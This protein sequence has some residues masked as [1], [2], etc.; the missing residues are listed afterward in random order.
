MKKLV[1][2]LLSSLIFLLLGIP[3]YANVVLTD[4]EYD[5]LLQRLKSDK[6][7]LNIENIRWEELKKSKPK[8]TY[9]II[10]DTVVIQTIEIPI[11]NS[12]PLIY[13]VKFIVEK[14]ENLKWVPWTFQLCGTVETNYSIGNKFN[15][16][17]D[18]KLGVRFFST[19]PAGIKF[20]TIGFN[21]FIGIR[22]AGLSMSY[23]LPK[24][25]KNTS[26]HVYVGV[27]YTAKVAYGL[28]ISL[29]F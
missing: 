3:L 19:A 16:Y 13:E 17:P 5:A 15:V 10:D 22:S 7:L 14:K 28:G 26:I 9:E 18:V 25:L 23:S 1:R 29:N 27:A 6:Y 8:I 12:K 20:L 21:V 2:R 4:S 24:P 11:Y